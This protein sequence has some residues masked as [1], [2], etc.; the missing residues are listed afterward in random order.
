[1]LFFKKKKKENTKRVKVVETTE[2]I[3]KTVSEIISEQTGCDKDSI[4]LETNL[5]EVCGYKNYSGPDVLDVLF[6]I[7]TAFLIFFTDEETT[8]MFTVEDVVNTIKKN[9]D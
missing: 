7:Q 4:T 2:S 6:E 5:Y 9:L 3:F 1:M 8:S